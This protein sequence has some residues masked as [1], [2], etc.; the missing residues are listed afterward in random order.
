MKEQV[1]VRITLFIQKEEIAVEYILGPNLLKCFLWHH[2]R[3][4]D[5][6]KRRY[7][8]LSCFN[9]QLGWLLIPFKGERYPS[10]EIIFIFFQLAFNSDNSFY[11]SYQLR[12]NDSCNIH[13]LQWKQYPETLLHRLFKHFCGTVVSFTLINFWMKARNLWQCSRRRDSSNTDS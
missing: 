13:C 12:I 9:L 1:R 7:L 10:S 6:N 8:R 3:Y 4:S 11:T 5:K 2:E